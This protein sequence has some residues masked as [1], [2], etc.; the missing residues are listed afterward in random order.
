[1]IPEQLVVRPPTVYRRLTQLAQALRMQL[2]G[3]QPLRR[4][5]RSANASD[6]LVAGVAAQLDEL[7]TRGRDL[8]AVHREWLPQSAAAAPPGRIVWA[9]EKFR[10]TLR[11]AT[12]RVCRSR[13]EPASRRTRHEREPKY[14]RAIQ[15]RSITGSPSTA[16]ANPTGVQASTTAA[17]RVTSRPHQDRQQDHDQQRMRPVGGR[18]KARQYQNVDGGESKWLNRPIRESVAKRK[19]AGTPTR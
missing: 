5:L 10:A 9:G 18:L 3:V 15:S 4:A 17:R 19:Y 2:E 7:L 1:M 14:C 12:E 6:A 11:P 16:T 8:A 13:C